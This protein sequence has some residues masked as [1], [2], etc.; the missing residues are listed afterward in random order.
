M[1]KLSS[2]S[3]WLY[4]FVFLIVVSAVLVFVLFVLRGGFDSSKFSDREVEAG[5]LH[6]WDIFIVIGVMLAGMMAHHMVVIQVLGLNPE[7]ADFG[8]LSGQV[9]VS[10]V[11][12]GQV[13]SQLPAGILFIWRG[14]SRGG[15]LY[16]IGITTSRTMKCLSAGVVGW[17]CVTPVILTVMGA[18]GI[19]GTLTGSEPPEI[20]HDLLQVLVNSDSLPARCLMIF[21]A[22]CLAPILEELIFRGFVQ[23]AILD[24]SIPAGGNGVR[25]NSGTFLM[26]IFFFLPGWNRRWGAILMASVIF[27]SIHLSVVTWHGWP[28]LF[29]LAVFLGWL[30]ERTGSLWPSMVA[31]GCFNM[32]N[33]VMALLVKDLSV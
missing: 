2:S 1:D 6:V 31:H 32:F 29:I 3:Y 14:R 8:S 20:G 18:A 28:G 33:I 21:S 9:Q 24:L 4:G 30:Y 10:L 16:S 22:V 19:I 7:A 23:T 5:R 12:L 26:A 27:V 13:I 11:I 25:F 15:G 17:L